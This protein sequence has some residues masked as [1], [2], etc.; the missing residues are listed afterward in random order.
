MVP[1]DTHPL[2][3]FPIPGA[4]LGH[5]IGLKMRK[6]V[7]MACGASGVA[8]RMDFYVGRTFGHRD[9]P[10]LEDLAYIQQLL[11]FHEIMFLANPDLDD[12]LPG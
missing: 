12:S 11:A 6:D 8:N 2:I 10:F 9:N 1:E 4:T 7:A 3:C 5:G